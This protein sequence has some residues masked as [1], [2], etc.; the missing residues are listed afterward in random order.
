[1]N[2][3]EVAGIDGD[4]LL[5]V[6]KILGRRLNADWV[7]LSARNTGVGAGAGAEAVFGLGRALFYAGTR[8]LLVNQL[9]R[10]SSHLCAKLRRMVLPVSGAEQRT[11]A[12]PPL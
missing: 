7:V 3:P 12:L 1:M 10:P 11:F 2:H 9:A 5:T 8:A 4:G 6:D